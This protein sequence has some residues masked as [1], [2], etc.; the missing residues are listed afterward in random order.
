MPKLGLAYFLEVGKLEKL[1]IPPQHNC[2]KFTIEQGKL[3][4]ID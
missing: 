2:S 1:A 3:L 4:V